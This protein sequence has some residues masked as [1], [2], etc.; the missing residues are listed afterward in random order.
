MPRPRLPPE[1]VRVRLDLTLPRGLVEFLTTL[2]TAAG[3]SR[4]EIVSRLVEAER[5]RVQHR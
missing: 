3:V 5:R 1:A 4:S 2:A